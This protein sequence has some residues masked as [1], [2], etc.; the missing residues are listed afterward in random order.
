MSHAGARADGASALRVLIA[1]GG[2]A[3]LEALLA[4]RA[5]AAGRV[6]VE[7]AAPERDFAS[8]PLAVAEQ[9]GYGRAVRFDLGD[10]VAGQGARFRPDSLVAVDPARRR[11]LMRSGVEIAYDALV[12]ACGA[13][14]VEALPGAVTFWGTGGDLG[15]VLETAAGGGRRR[16]VFAVP[17]APGWPL[18][19][20]ELAL[21]VQRELAA[22]GATGVEIS[23]VTPEAAPLEIFGARASELVAAL[24]E[25][26]GIPVICG[27]RPRS[28]SGDGLSLVPAA[29]LA[30]EAV[31][32]IPRQSG[33]P[34]EGLPRDEES[35]I[36]VDI[37]CR[38]NGLDR[39]HAVGDATAFPV[40][41]GGIAAQQ[42]D[43]AA[44]VIAAEAG[45]AVDPQPFRPVLRGLLLT[46]G[47]PA[48]MQAEL[49]GGRGESSVA[50]GYPLWWP[51]GK[52]AGRYL[53][54]HLASLTGFELHPRP[55][56][57]G[58]S[59][60]VD[61][62]LSPDAPRPGRARATG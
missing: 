37:H 49:S 50:A 42:A 51:P 52:I 27:R 18:P 33:R 40:K 57:E 41:Q 43:A 58:E 25:R 59:V 46:G 12:V 3:G 45:A 36:P 8:R 34:I 9:L 54:P 31:V 47:E 35:F 39:V 44:Q 2:V 29:H 26:R 11:A 56:L 1:G 48:F 30:A 38:V 24:L 16:I 28:V 17:G 32:S 10:L 4:L 20:Y 55:P 21:L 61:V 19:V 5:L 13:R 14:S 7:L 15:A 6:E 62:E 60:V 23:I 22:R 53:A